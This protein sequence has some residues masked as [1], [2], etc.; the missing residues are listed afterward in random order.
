[1][2]AAMNAIILS[3][4][5][6]GPSWQSA[7]VA[8]ML[9][10]T[11]ASIMIASIMRYDLDGTI[12]VWSLLGPLVGIV[13]GSFAG[14]FFAIPATSQFNADKSQFNEQISSV[15]NTASSASKNIVELQEAIQKLPSVTSLT[16][17]AAQPAA[18]R[19]AATQEAAWREN[20]LQLTSRINSSASQLSQISKT[21]NGAAR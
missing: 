19:A 13:V 11:L 7:V 5:A 9:L 16:S 8:G 14:Y 15:A 10:L 17:P 2:D 3:D 4:V 1:M 6:P 18:I 21:A 12:K 20:L